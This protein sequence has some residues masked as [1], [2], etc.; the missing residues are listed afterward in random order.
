MDVT[1]LGAVADLANT[2]IGRIF[3]DKTEQERQQL[4]MALTV[5]QGQFD[6]NKNEAANP[7]IFVAG[8]RPFVGW[9]CGGG[10]A[11]QF[12]LGPLLQWAS[13][14]VGHT[15][16]FPPLDLG[17]MMPLLLGMLG[18]GGM[19]TVEKVQGVNSGH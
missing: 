6:A 2:I 19:R 8:W 13:G 14:L 18:L 12:V 5:I 10:F 1:G 4:A 3:P 15:V 9:V 17:T 11:M 7:S 16:T